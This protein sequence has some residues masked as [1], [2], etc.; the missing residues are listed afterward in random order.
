[1]GVTRRELLEC[2][3]GVP[4]AA[5]L[6]ARGIKTYVVGFGN[7]V[8]AQNLSEMA[9]SGGTARNAMPRYFQ[10]DS[11][12]ELTSA[13]GA[14]AQGAVGCD[15]KL[16][17]TPP[18]PS[19]IFVSVNGQLIPRDP[20]RVAGWEYTAGSDRVTLYGPACDV[21]VNQPGSQVSLVYG[22]A[23]PSLVGDGGYAF[24]TD[25]GDLIN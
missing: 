10:A 2:L 1:M 15:F 18:D 3:L 6:A 23:D 14:I 21:V 24:P 13:F 19:K 11:P 9:V 20:N 4:A 7:E 17:K 12:A 25:A 22:C 5:A 16:G 8:N